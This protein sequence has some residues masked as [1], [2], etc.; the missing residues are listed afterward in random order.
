MAQNSEIWVVKKIVEFFDI[1]KIGTFPPG[2]QPIS[3]IFKN[4][5]QGVQNTIFHTY[6]QILDEISESRV[7]LKLSQMCGKK[8]ILCSMPRR[9]P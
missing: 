3:D 8:D 6:G 5:N 4:P 1:S 7:P 9:T 2:K